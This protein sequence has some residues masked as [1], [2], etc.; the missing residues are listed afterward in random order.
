MFISKWSALF[1]F[2]KFPMTSTAIMSPFERTYV[3]WSIS[4][5]HYIEM[6]NNEGWSSKLLF[7]T[8]PNTMDFVLLR[9]RS[10]LWNFLRQTKVNRETLAIAGII[11]TI[12]QN[13]NM[14]THFKLK[15]TKNRRNKRYETI[16]T[17]NKYMAVLTLMSS[18]SPNIFGST[19][20]KKK[21]KECWKQN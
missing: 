5:I 19:V 14:K 17:C 11:L 2:F 4:I 21:K 18:H 20:K 9:H 10:L 12:M 1:F 7:K 3:L 16:K 13:K 15:N 8:R 6:P